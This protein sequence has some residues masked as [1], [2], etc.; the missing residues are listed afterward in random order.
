MINLDW[1]NQALCS[2]DNT[3]TELFFPIQGQAS[4]QKARA[5][6]ICQQ[7]PVREECLTYALTVPTL[8]IHNGDAHWVHGI[9]GGTTPMER[10]QLRAERGITKNG[11]SDD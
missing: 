6:A 9:W 7:C 10:K 2:E 4:G 5:K 8:D 1:Q 3:T 11:V